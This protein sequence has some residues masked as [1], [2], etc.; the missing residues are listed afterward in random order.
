MCSSD[1]PGTY[2]VIVMSQI[3]EH[4]LDVNLWLTKCRDLLHRGGVI[5][6]A[7]PNFN[8]VFR[9]V[10]QENEP[11]ITPPAHLNY[12]SASNLCRLLERHGFAVKQVDSRSRLSAASLRR[13]LPVVGPAL[14]GIVRAAFAGIDRLHLGMMIQVYAVKA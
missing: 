11:F 9:R 14:S 7:L 8:S 4:A 13:R 1:P 3:L 5:A 2:S 12:F 6:I 10:M